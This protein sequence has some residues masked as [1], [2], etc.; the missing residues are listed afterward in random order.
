V[1]AHAGLGSR[2]ACEELI[3]QGRVTVD[4][5]VVRELGTKVD[6]ERAG[7]AVDG[8]PI[9]QERMVYFAVNKP[10]GYVSTNDDPAGRP[11]VVD[12]LPEIPERVYNVGR[13]DEQS[14]G[15]M[16][17]TN[18][19]ELANKLMHP[20]FGVEKVYRALVAG[21]PTRE[22][23]TQLT[24]GVW[25][26]EGKARAQRARVVGHKGDATVLELVL[27]EGKNREVR[28]ILARLGHKVMTLTRI[29]VGPIGLRGLKV[30]QFRPLAP[31]EVFQLRQAAE[32]VPVPRERE[33]GPRDRRLSGRGPRRAERPRG[34]RAPVREGQGPPPQRRAASGP[35]APAPRRPR[36]PRTAPRPT[37][38]P[39]PPRAGPP[40]SPSRRIIGLNAGPTA[41]GPSGP[42]ARRPAPKR[43]PRPVSKPR[44]RRE[45]EGKGDGGEDRGQ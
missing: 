5:K 15:L 11:R 10:R 39:E 32:G 37:P 2:R 20:R 24:E 31:R 34:P 7:I 18:D 3:L 6:P 25:L 13:L 23:L 1:L 12:L 26:A 22:V 40:R 19:G 35:P 43:R 42:P 33:H 27:A 17:L 38:T 30:G 16:I 21:Q 44:R 8:E 45:T 36:G 41:G 28:R 14:T 29:A 4:G 9:R